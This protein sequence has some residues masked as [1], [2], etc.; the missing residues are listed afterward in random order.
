MTK[1]TIDRDFYAPIFIR[2]LIFDQDHAGGFDLAR[3]AMDREA[4]LAA[5]ARKIPWAKIKRELTGK[6]TDMVAT[7]YAPKKLVS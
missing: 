4:K 7:Y 3:S 1:Q 6:P 2:P 5:K